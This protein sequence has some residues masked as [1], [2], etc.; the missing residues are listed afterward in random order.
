MRANARAIAS[1]DAG[2]R[3]ENAPVAAPAPASA[4][5]ALSSRSARSPLLNWWLTSTPSHTT[6]PADAERSFAIATASKPFSAAVSSAT[7][8]TI[9]VIGTWPLIAPAAFSSRRVGSSVRR[10][11]RCGRPAT[12]TVRAIGGASPIENSDSSRPERRTISSATAESL[13]P[14]TGTRIRCGVAGG[15]AILA[16]A[17][18]GRIDD[19]PP[20]KRW[21][22]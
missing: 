19:A 20:P 12:A 7:H 4:S 18:S 16:T 6:L 14:P 10:A 11:I 22:W 3:S 9:A 2:R 17:V 1:S 15:C 8:D 13:P 5:A 21:A